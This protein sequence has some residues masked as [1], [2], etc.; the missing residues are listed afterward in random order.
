MSEQFGIDTIQPYYSSDEAIL[1]SAL[2][3]DNYHD[4]RDNDILKNNMQQNNAIQNDMETNPQDYEQYNHPATIEDSTHDFS[5]QMTSGSGDQEG[6]FIQALLP[7]LPIIG[8]LLPTLFNGIK[9]LFSKKKEGQ[10]VY[11][12]NFRGS[13]MPDLQRYQ[14]SRFPILKG[15]EE[16]LKNSR[17][18]KFYDT[19]RNS[20]KKE[21]Y[22]VINEFAPQIGSISQGVADKVVDSVFD[23]FV[24]PGF[25][26]YIHRKPL[27]SGGS[28]IKPAAKFLLN[29]ILTDGNA[30]KYYSRKMRDMNADDD[31]SDLFGSG[32]FWPNFK[33]KLKKFLSVLLPGSSKILGTAIDM[34]LKKFGNMGEPGRQ[35]ISGLA[36]N[37]TNAVGNTL[38]SGEMF[39]EGLEN[40]IIN[41][42]NRE[43]PVEPTRIIQ[44]DPIVEEPKVKPKRKPRK[45]ARKTKTL[46]TVEKTTVG[47]GKSKKK[48]KFE[49]ELL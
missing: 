31:D 46:K 3:N 39:G 26:S 24:M 13:G 29:D 2:T 37:I 33:V 15:Y 35:M 19:L 16:E 38:G 25:N 42:I 11:L 17:G 6:G 45:K 9:S 20:I 23:K 43:V 18:S 1:L 4:I 22:N 47:R 40:D 44:S 48:T 27:K 30:V 34:A 21:V 49:I 10:G 36:E 5:G 28:I 14:T 32:T 12:P 8:S 7:F 41:Q